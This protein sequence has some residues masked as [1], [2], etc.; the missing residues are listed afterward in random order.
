ML[1]LLVTQVARVLPAPNQPGYKSYTVG[2]VLDCQ[3]AGVARSRFSRGDCGLPV[4][5]LTKQ[6]LHLF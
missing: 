6:R 3:G 2:T 5:K 4:D 1:L